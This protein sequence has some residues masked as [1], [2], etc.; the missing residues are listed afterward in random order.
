MT[1][2]QSRKI[3]NNVSTILSF[4]AFFFNQLKF[5]LVDIRVLSVSITRQ[6]L[7]QALRSKY[8]RNSNRIL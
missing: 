4:K 3:K 2:Y 5:K 1:F 7:H 6:L 8:I